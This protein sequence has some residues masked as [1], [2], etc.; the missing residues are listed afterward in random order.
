MNAHPRPVG[1]IGNR[2]LID[3][4]FVILQPGVEHGIEPLRFVLIA[5]DDGW[6]F[7]RKIAEEHVRLTL[8]RPGPAHLQH[9]PLENLAA[10]LHRARQK[11][12]GF[13]GEIDHDR[14]GFKDREIILVTVDDCRDA[15]VGIELEIIGLLLIALA[16]FQRVHSV[17]Q[18]Q[19][20]EHNR[21]LPTVR[22]RGGI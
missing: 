5:R 12:A 6:N 4:I 2:I 3:E 19:F 17:G 15:P 9:E 13:F 7:L 14:A 11:L 21:D 8:H 18:P 1:D 16:K 20:L 10:R 22:R